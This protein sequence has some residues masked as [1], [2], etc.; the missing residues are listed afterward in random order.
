MRAAFP[1]ILSQIHRLERTE[2]S[3]VKLHFQDEG[4]GCGGRGAVFTQVTLA[5]T[6]PKQ[7]GWAF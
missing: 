1:G 7:K 6:D 2:S 4:P 3:G 5:H